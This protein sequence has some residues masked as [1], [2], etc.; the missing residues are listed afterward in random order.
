[1]TESTG[2]NGQRISGGGLTYE[3]AHPR[4]N[5]QMILHRFQ[6]D[7]RFLL[8]QMG[9]SRGVCGMAVC[10]E[11][12]DKA[13]PVVVAQIVGIIVGFSKA[14]AHFHKSLTETRKMQWLG[15]CDHPIEVKNNRRQRVHG[16]FSILSVW[17]RDRKRADYSIG[18]PSEQ[19]GDISARRA[20]VQLRGNV[21]GS[22]LQAET[23]FRHPT[24]DTFLRFDQIHP[25]SW[26]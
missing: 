4:E 8:H 17:F 1:M 5:D 21:E 6:I 3:F 14:D 13:A 23:F 10:G 9:E 15:V 2:C 11:C 22:E 18:M 12:S 19:V 16:I 26:L 24:H 7:M 20:T 25:A